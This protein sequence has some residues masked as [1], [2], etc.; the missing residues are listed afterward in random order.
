MAGCPDVG[1][2]PLRAGAGSAPGRDRERCVTLASHENSPGTS[3]VRPSAAFLASLS[4]SS[5]PATPTCA[6]TQKTVTSLSPLTGREQTSTTA[7][8]KCWPGSMASDRIRL[9]AAVEFAKIVRLGCPA[10]KLGTCAVRSLV[11]PRAGLPSIVAFWL[12]AS[13]SRGPIALVAVLKPTLVFPKNSSTAPAASPAHSHPTDGALGC[14][15]R[16]SFT[17]LFHSL[18]I[19]GD[20]ARH[21]VKK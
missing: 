20:Q 10:V 18:L 13:C 7:L 9:M 19:W 5:L 11:Q 21:S 15:Q 8:A 17:I 12:L 14:S 1:G 2:H 6:G 4:A 3:W 16:Q